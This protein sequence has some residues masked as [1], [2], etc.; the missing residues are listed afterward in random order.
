ML[1]K[2]TLCNLSNLGNLICQGAARIAAPQTPP[3][4]LK[5]NSE[6]QTLEET[7]YTPFLLLKTFPVVLMKCLC[8]VMRVS[9]LFVV[10]YYKS[11]SID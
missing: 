1:A 2:F 7:C 3:P 11:K 6:T 10:D 9:H 8:H 5:E 4:Q